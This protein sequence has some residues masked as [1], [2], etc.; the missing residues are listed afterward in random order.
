MSKVIPVVFCFDKRIL[1]GASVAV[2]SLIDC[3]KEDTTYDIR[4]FH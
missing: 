4:I 2:K 1:L 3:A